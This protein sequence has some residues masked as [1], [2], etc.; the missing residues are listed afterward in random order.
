VSYSRPAARLAAAALITLTTAACQRDEAERVR[1]R[2]EY[3]EGDT[4]R[5]AYHSEGTVTIPD[6]AAPGG[7]TTRDY[8]R[9]MRIEEVAEEVTPRGHYRLAVTYYLPPDTTSGAPAPAPI[10][11][12]LELTPQ[13]KIQSV[14]GVETA[15]P[16][17]GDIDFQ[18]YFEQAQP[19]FP[20]RPLKVGDSWTQEVRVMTA[21]AEPVVTSS[22]YV[23]ESIG[24]EAGRPIATIAFDG[25][26]YLPIDHGASASGSSGS[27]D[28]TRQLAEERIRVHGRMTFDYERGITRRVETTAQATVTKVAIEAGA[29]SRQDLHIAERSEIRLTEP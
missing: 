15:K 17:F 1:L 21:A 4:L 14:S 5:Y 2:F 25:E 8:Q 27:S 23:L 9:T 18:S 7:S 28:A 11:I 12:R 10:T 22:T 3:S 13:G 29:T 16:L 20:E 24:E 19:V 26:I 6:T